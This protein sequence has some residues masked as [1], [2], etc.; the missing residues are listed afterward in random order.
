MSSDILTESYSK[1]L[2]EDL[3]K[4][5]KEDNVTTLAGKLSISPEVASKISKIEIENAIDKVGWTLKEEEKN[6][7]NCLPNF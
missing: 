6:L 4:L 3:F 7:I 5:I 2:A 1:T